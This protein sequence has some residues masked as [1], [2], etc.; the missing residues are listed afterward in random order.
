MED[1]LSLLRRLTGTGG[2]G[3]GSNNSRRRKHTADG[4]AMED[5]VPDSDQPG[6]KET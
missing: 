5:D 4:W 1:A 3:N 6:K 2:S